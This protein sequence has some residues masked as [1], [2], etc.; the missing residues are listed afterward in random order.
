MV[1]LLAPLPGTQR[2]QMAR[3]SVDDLSSKRRGWIHVSG[4]EAARSGRDDDGSPGNSCIR[5][6]DRDVLWA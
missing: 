1:L 5:N 3:T 2:A 6:T 4:G